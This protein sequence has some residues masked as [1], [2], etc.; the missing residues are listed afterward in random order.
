[1]EPVFR[2]SKFVQ[3]VLENFST[4]DTSAA[5]YSCYLGLSQLLEALRKTP[6]LTDGESVKNAL[7]QTSQFP[8]LDGIVQV[9]DREIQ[10]EI[11]AKVISAGEIHALAQ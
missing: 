4:P 9:R 7:E 10:F 5:G 3:A 1:M 2:R 11:E 6:G 8:S